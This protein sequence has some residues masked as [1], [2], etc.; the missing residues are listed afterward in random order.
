MKIKSLNTRIAQVC[1]ITL[2]LFF[3]GCNSGSNEKGKTAVP[4]TDT[5]NTSTEG[6]KTAQDDTSINLNKYSNDSDSS[7]IYVTPDSN[8]DN[9]TTVDK[10]KTETSNCPATLTPNTDF[11]LD[12][13]SDSDNE[14]LM[15][16]ATITFHDSTDSNDSLIGAAFTIYNTKPNGESLASF[17]P[18]LVQNGE[19][20]GP[21]TKVTAK[22]I[23]KDGIVLVGTMDGSDQF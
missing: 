13:Y 15:S 22:Y 7:K 23:Q 21:P 1:I 14:N 2:S 4:S 19:K 11:V 18:I 17:G 10:N 12:V 20:N 16:K 5:E 6:A 8:C 3:F 9:T